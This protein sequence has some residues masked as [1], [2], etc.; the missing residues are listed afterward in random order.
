MQTLCPDDGK[1]AVGVT[2][3]EDSIGLDSSHQLV[4]LCNDVAAGFT[5]VFPDCVQIHIRIGK[6][7]VSKKYAV[8]VVVV[9]LTC[10]GE[11]HVKIYTSF[12]NHSGKTDDLRPC[13]ND[14]QQFQFAVV[15]KMNICKIIY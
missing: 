8:Q 6:L 13:A 5:E 2:K 10:V 12:V 9:I 15:L 11:N 4:A 3:N 14:D 1:A 7:Q